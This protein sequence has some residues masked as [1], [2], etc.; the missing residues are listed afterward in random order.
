M[1]NTMLQRFK[2]EKIPADF[3]ATGKQ[4]GH[5]IAIG[6]RPVGVGINVA[7]VDLKIIITL[8][9]ILQEYCGL[10]FQRTL[11]ISNYYLPT[12]SQLME[13]YCHIQMNFKNKQ[14]I[15]EIIIKNII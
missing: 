15:I 13:S 8:P 4:Q 11:E 12:I 5:L 2:I 14:I 6:W 3:V 10:K 9:Q 7:Q 1:H